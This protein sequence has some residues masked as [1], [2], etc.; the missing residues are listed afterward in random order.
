MI[1]WKIVARDKNII[2]TNSERR[3][4]TLWYAGMRRMRIEELR[5]RDDTVINIFCNEVVAFCSGNTRVLHRVASANTQLGSFASTRVARACENT[6]LLSWPAYSSTL[7]PLPSTVTIP[8][9]K[10]L[11]MVTVLGSGS[12]RVL[13]PRAD[14]TRWSTIHTPTAKSDNFVAKYINYRVV[15][16]PKFLAGHPPHACVPK[17]TLTTYGIS[18]HNICCLSPILIPNWKV[19]VPKIL[20]AAPAFDQIW[21][22][23]NYSSIFVDSL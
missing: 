19:F 5:K 10:A 23:S 1:D 16:L 4:C 7:L 21:T 2:R 11:G 9:A 22:D 17:F 20:E 13:R 14:A 3:L 6:S 18:T 15:P 8:R 12:T